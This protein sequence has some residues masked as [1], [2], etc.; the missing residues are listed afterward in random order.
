MV[1]GSSGG[2]KIISSLAKPVVRVLF[3][4]ETIKEAI[5]APT[6][7]NQFTPD[8]TQFEHSVPKVCYQF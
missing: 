7:H 2:S 4:N 5:D 1:A 8:V 6:L 3:F